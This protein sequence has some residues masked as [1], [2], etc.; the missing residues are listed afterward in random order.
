MTREEKIAY[1]V[2]EYSKFK[3]DYIERRFTLTHSGEPK[4]YARPRFTRFGGKNGHGR[5]Y[6][7]R[8]KYMQGLKDDFLESMRLEDIALVN[9]LVNAQ[10]DYYVY[11]SGRFY[12]PIPKSDTIEITAKKLAGIIKPANKKGDVDNYIKL[13]LDVL[14][15]VTYD[16]DKHVIG[17]TA[18]KIYSTDPRIELDIT[19]RYRGD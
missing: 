15:D 12:L 19:I 16:D 4:P 9:E 13:V 5:C 10:K 11:V 3:D 8:D 18:E 7:T 2:K 14:H 17:I 1:W 6:N